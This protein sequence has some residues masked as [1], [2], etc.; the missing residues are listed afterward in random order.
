MPELQDRLERFETLTAECELIAKLAT[1]STKR[2]FYLKLSEQYRQLA[3]DMRQAIA[4]KAAE[5]QAAA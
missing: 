4:T 5:T 3:L 1:D 2:E